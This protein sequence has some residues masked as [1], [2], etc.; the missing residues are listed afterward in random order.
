M[1]AAGGSITRA[2]PL[3]ILSAAGPPPALRRAGLPRRRI[4]VNLCR[5]HREADGGGL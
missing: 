2:G 4:I 3:A 5:N 1:V